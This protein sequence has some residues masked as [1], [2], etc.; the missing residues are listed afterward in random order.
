MRFVLLHGNGG[1]T[2]S[3]HWHPAVAA[4]LRSQGH[5]ALTPDLPD[6]VLARAR[7][8]LPYLREELRVD[9]GT[10]LVG[11]S[12]GA[13]AAMR[14]AEQFPIRGSALVGACYTDLGMDDEKA[15]GY[16]DAPWQWDSIRSNQRWVT[17]FASP[18]DPWIPLAEARHIA[19]RLAG[20][21]VEMP[22]RG[23]FAD[24]P[25]SHFPELAH[26]LLAKAAQE[27]EPS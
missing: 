3:G 9:A 17:V 27:P 22:G 14:Y 16:Y 24:G 25:G 8:W 5:E 20:E 11:H 6:P 15:S 12:S 4:A 18:D 19:D 13:V 23:H 10:V 2:G 21:Y 7:Y 26:W 1:L